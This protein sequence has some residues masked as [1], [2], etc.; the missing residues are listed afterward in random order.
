M[1]ARHPTSERSGDTD[2]PAAFRNRLP[3]RMWGMYRGVTGTRVPIYCMNT[4][5]QIRPFSGNGETVAED[6][7]EADIDY[8]SLASIYGRIW[9]RFPV[10]PGVL[11]KM[12][13]R[14]LTLGPAVRQV[15]VVRGQPVALAEAFRSPYYAE[16][17]HFQ[18][19][20]G[21]VP[22]YRDRATFARLSEALESALAPYDPTRLVTCASDNDAAALAFA[23]SQ[24]YELFQRETEFGLYLPAFE[25]RPY[26]P[27]LEKPAAFGIEILPVAALAQ[28]PHRDRRLWELDAELFSQIPGEQGSRPEFEPWREEVLERD[29]FLDEGSFVARDRKSGEYV[30]VTFLFAEEPKDATIELTGVRGSHRRMGLATALKLSSMIWGRETGLDRLYTYNDASNEPI[31]RLNESLGFEATFDWLMLHR[32]LDEEAAAVRAS[33]GVNA[34]LRSSTPTAAT[35]TAAVA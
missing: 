21:A 24:G 22:G 1:A 2:R 31:R 12:D 25:P 18:V 7:E 28:D 33:Q 27:K 30:G 5:I 9:P 8:A 23:Y 32:L 11:R 4:E 6:S 15:A 35:R 16:R 20:V 10:D 26:V 17:G 13:R 29:D 34:A 14:R 3:H 19:R